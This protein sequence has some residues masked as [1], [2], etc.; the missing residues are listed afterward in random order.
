MRLTPIS[1]GNVLFAFHSKL[2][3]ISVAYL[4]IVTFEEKEAE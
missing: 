2:R 4:T 1:S 3:S